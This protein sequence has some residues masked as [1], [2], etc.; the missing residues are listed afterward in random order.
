MAMHVCVEE[1][2]GRGI[3]QRSGEAKLQELAASLLQTDSRLDGAPAEECGSSHTD[4]RFHLWKCVYGQSWSG[5]MTVESLN[6]VLFT[7]SNAPLN[8]N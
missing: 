6:G 7:P 4:P 1:R 2:R 5:Y 3:Q 8:S